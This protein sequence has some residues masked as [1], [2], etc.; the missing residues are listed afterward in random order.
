NDR[1]F[2]SVDETLKA[3]LAANPQM[4]PDNIAIDC[5]GAGNRLR[6]V[7][8]C[9]DKAGEF[10]SC[11]QNEDQRRLCNAARMYVPPTRSGNQSPVPRS[12]PLQPGERRI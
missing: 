1:M 8:I 11:G 6:E 12:S 2:V 10:R 5:G 7:R 4:K 9:F 3:F